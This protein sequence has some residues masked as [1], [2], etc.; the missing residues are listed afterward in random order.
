MAA[1]TFYGGVGEIGGT[2]ILLEHQDTRVLLDFGMSFSR[3]SMYFSEF[4]QPRKCSSLNDFFEFGLL[5]DIRGVYRTDYL[6]HMGRI[7][8]KRGIDGLLLSHAHA[9]HAQYLHFLRKDIPVYCTRET[10]IILE[11]LEA[12]GS[13]PFSDLV[14]TCEAFTYYENKKGTPSRVTRKREEYIKERKFLLMDPLSPVDIG[15]M[16][17]EMVPVDHSLPGACAFVVYTDDGSLVYS[18]DIRFH[19]SRQEL[20]RKF[21]E[22]SRELEPKWLVLEGT[23]IDRDESDSEEDVKKKIT[24]LISKS[25]GLVFVEY[26]TRDL[27]RVRSI[28][29][30][31]KNNKR[32]FVVSMKLAYLIRALGGMSPLGL[33]DVKILIPKKG[34]GLIDRKDVSRELLEKDYEKWEREFIGGENSLTYKEL[35]KS[36]EK[37]VVSMNLWEINQL[38]DIKPEGAIWIKSTCEPFNEEMELDEERKKN[39][40]SHF[41]IKEYFAHASGHASRT[42]LI[43]IVKTISPK[44]LFPIHTENPSGFK[45]HLEG[46]GI[47]VVPPT[48]R[49]PYSL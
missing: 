41:Q 5:P 37:F 31:S 22:R 30:A 39:W 18:G 33:S 10:K 47:Q 45:N 16:K 46:S 15:S 44:M 32:E 9:D 2:K 24:D 7:E 20:S 4:V 21:I 1:L 23:R 19:G 34:W 28:L 13:N 12:T 6:A 27:Y 40:L 35:Q 3:A 14:T 17:V 48:P 43:D 29:E 25:H 36:P 8:E 42:E 49:A 38:A 11:A 26:P